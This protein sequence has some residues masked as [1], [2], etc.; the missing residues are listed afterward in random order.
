VTTYTL[1]TPM[2]MNCGTIDAPDPETA[3]K[4]AAAPPYCEKVLDVMD[5]YLVVADE[6]A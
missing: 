4:I 6:E 1:M 2:G 3:K 5:D